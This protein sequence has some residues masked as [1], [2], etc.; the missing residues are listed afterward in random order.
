MCYPYVNYGKNNVHCGHSSL[1]SHFLLHL[2]DKRPGL[3]LPSVAVMVLGYLF[4]HRVQRLKVFRGT[5]KPL[6][7]TH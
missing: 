2:Q 1:A 4:H 6:I 5:Y 3:Y 7:H